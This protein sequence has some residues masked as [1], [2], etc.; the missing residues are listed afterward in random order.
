[1]FS[2]LSIDG[3]A[4]DADSPNVFNNRIYFLNGLSPPEF[5]K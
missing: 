1:M 3:S 4:K 2:F 5:A